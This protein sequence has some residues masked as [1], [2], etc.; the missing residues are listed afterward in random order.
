MK[1]KIETPPGFVDWIVKQIV[2]DYVKKVTKS[3]K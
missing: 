2:E 3:Y 1:K